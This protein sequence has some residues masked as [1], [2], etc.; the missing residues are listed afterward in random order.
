[1]KKTLLLI[2]M[3]GM[4]LL[5]A[6]CNNDDEP[7]RSNSVATVTYPMFN[8][9]TADGGN[10]VVGIFSTQNKLVL[11]TAT[12]KATLELNYSD[13]QGSKQ[14]TLDDVVATSTPEDP[15]FYDLTSPSYRSFKGYA[16]FNQLSFCYSYTTTGGLHVISMT[17]EVFFL[18]TNTTVTYDDATPATTDEISNYIFNINA[19]NKT[20]TVQVTQILHAKDLKN[21]ESITAANVPITLTPNGFTIS[22]T[23]LPTKGIYKAYDYETGSSVKETDQYPFKTFNATVDL[24]N[25]TMTANFMMGGS[26]TVTATG[27]TY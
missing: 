12:H 15:K 20:A 24:V 14:L 5:A 19:A 6:S 27:R 22:A 26:A 21:F 13:S 18:K 11:D 23:N 7:K 2:A 25:G 17:P 1:M 8:H 10:T 16:N 9:I 3:T 4:L